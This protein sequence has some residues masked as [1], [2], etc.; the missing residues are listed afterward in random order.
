MA[1][2]ALVNASNEWSFLRSVLVGRAGQACFPAIPKVSADATMP[3]THAHR[4]HPE[5]SLPFPKHIVQKAEAELDCFASLLQAEGIQVYRP[6]TGIDWSA[7]RGYTGAMPRDGLLV[8]GNVIIEACFAWKCRGREVE[9]AYGAL[10]DKL[11]EDGKTIVVRRPVDSY[12]DV[13]EPSGAGKAPWTINNSRPA[14][15]AADFLRFGKCILGQYSHVTN[16]AG[17]A[18]IRQHLPTG[19][20]VEMIEVSDPAAMHIDATILPLRHGLLVYN[21]F[22]VTEKAL[23][24]HEVLADWTLKA[25]PFIPEGPKE[26]PL[27]MTSPWLALNALVLDGRRMVVEASDERS[28]S[29]FE[30]LGMECLRCPF[31]HVNSIGGS[32][33]CASIDLLRE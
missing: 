33:H 3:S 18:W 15:D 27:F 28:A 9:L 12:A 16:E 2:Y 7:E 13:V 21:P 31:Q 24:A 19:Y 25:F 17:V 20:R 26:P 6:P 4:F 32:F 22:K 10:L 5:T 23:R 14:F 11:A 8:I 1:P 30:S 29:W